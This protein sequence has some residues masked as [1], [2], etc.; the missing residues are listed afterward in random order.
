MTVCAVTNTRRSSLNHVPS[1]NIASPS[2]LRTISPS[3]RISVI[4]ITLKV[5]SE[6]VARRTAVVTVK[7]K[8]P[9]AFGTPM[10]R[11]S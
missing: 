3:A 9:S 11:A 1:V 7:V 5:N 4:E 2:P 10:P 6:R 8:K